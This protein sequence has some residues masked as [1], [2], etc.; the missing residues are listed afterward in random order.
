[1]KLLFAMMLVFA[2]AA[3]WQAIHDGPSSKASG[4]LQNAHLGYQAQVDPDKFRKRSPV[5]I[6]GVLLLHGQ[7]SKFHQMASQST[8][9][10]HLMELGFGEAEVRPLQ[11][12]QNFPAREVTC[13]G[14]RQLQLS[15]TLDLILPWRPKHC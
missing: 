2:G 1:M 8:E 14:A 3:P 9:M 15:N 5:L 13:H 10:Q 7:A 4:M 12:F 6:S 11:R